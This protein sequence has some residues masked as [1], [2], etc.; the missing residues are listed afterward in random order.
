MKGRESKLGRAIFSNPDYRHI[1]AEKMINSNPIQ[2]TVFTTGNTSYE[3]T[4]G[5]KGV[6]RIVD[7]YK[8]RIEKRYGIK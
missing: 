4:G 3:I 5:F 2:G 1:I 8:A 6:D 7:G